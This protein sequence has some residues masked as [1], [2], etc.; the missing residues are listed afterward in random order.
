MS[1]SKKKPTDY[2]KPN[3]RN[4]PIIL[5]EPQRCKHILTRKGIRKKF[6]SNIFRQLRSNTSHI[7]ICCFSNC[8]VRIHVNTNGKVYKIVGTH[9]HSNPSDDNYLKEQHKMRLRSIINNNNNNNKSNLQLYEEYKLDNPSVSRVFHGYNEVKSFMQRES[10]KKASYIPPPKDFKSLHNWISNSKFRYNYWGAK[11][12]EINHSQKNRSITNTLNHTNHQIRNNLNNNNMTNYTIH[13]SN[14]NNTIKHSNENIYDTNINY[15]MKQSNKQNNSID[16][17]NINNMFNDTIDIKNS[18]SILYDPI[19]SDLMNRINNDINILQNHITNVNCKLFELNQMKLQISIDTKLVE[20]L[21]NGSYD[22]NFWFC[23]PLGLN[24]LAAGTYVSTDGTFSSTPKLSNVAD[25]MFPW[26]QVLT[27]HSLFIDNTAK[28]CVR[29]LCDCW[30]LKDKKQSTYELIFGEIAK[31]LK[32]F[33]LK[34]RCIEWYR[35]YEKGL[36]NAID[37][38]MLIK[39]TTKNSKGCLFHYDQVSSV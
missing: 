7:W 25:V 15:M 27:N 26:K 30:L 9:D 21:Y 34:L 5:S 38:K 31:T 35:D 3:V 20:C 8:K 37:K 18:N 28:N 39:H 19:D 23:S 22:G 14:F 16:N 24:R 4:Q 36:A 10:S 6:Q 11:L 13:N 32:K 17:L 2:L 12:Y 1:T 29:I 33:N